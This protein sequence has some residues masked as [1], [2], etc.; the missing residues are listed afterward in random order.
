MKKNKYILIAAVVAVISL[1]PLN[2]TLR[3]AD[4]TSDAQSALAKYSSAV[5][6]IKNT[7]FKNP[8][9][10]AFTSKEITSLKK[11]SKKSSG[12]NFL[13]VS[14]ST[15]HQKSLSSVSLN[16]LPNGNFEQGHTSWDEEYT[17]DGGSTWYPYDG[18][19]ESGS[20]GYDNWYASLIKDDALISSDF[21][22][23]VNSSAIN[24]QYQYELDNFGTCTYG[25]NA[26]SVALEDET[27]GTLH[28]FYHYPGIDPN[29]YSY[30]TESLSINNAQNLN[31]HKF[32]LDIFA[33]Q[34]D[35]NCDYIF[36]IDNISVT[37]TTSDACTG[38]T[39]NVYRFWSDKNQ[40]HF[41]TMSD[42]EANSVINNYPSDVW[43]YEGVAWTA[44][45]SQQPG[46]LPVYRFW[47]DKNQHH[48]FTISEDEKNHI[49]ATYPKNVW[50]YEGIAYYAYP[51]QQPNTTPV[52]RFWS[53]QNQGHFFT[54][55][56]NEKNHIIATYPK[57]VWDYEGI[58]W[59]VPTN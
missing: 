42:T 31:G 56:E 7:E 33:Y 21:G 9:K 2:N 34:D 4:Q 32:R 18:I 55:D 47:S 41:Y 57:N 15:T 46:T 24:L 20:G 23:P 51:T 39:C 30:E 40:G 54:I 53:D 22:I 43:N 3:A 50:N 37:T 19:I 35:P 49:I 8:I 44:F 11:L 6:K 10:E 59:Y 45:P 27:T 48:F 58:G 5:E 13:S 16:L 36:N 17:T 12:K 29:N 14:S 1:A 25:T 52:Y 26:V 38:T 28:P